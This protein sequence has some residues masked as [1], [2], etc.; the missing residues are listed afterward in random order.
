MTYKD[1]FNNCEAW[2]QR[3]TILNLYHVLMCVRDKNWKLADTARY[4]DKS[5]GYVSESISLANHIELVR[6][7]KTR[8]EALE[9]IR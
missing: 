9:R 6:E 5:I 1:K 2:H 4:F 7:C 8:K 3:A